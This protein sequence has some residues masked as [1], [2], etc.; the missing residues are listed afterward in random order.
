MCRKGLGLLG[1]LGLLVWL[2]LSSA[3][4][5]NNPNGWIQNTG[6]N[7]LFPIKTNVGCGGGGTGAMALNWTAPH[8]LRTEDPQ[9]GDSWNIGFQEGGGGASPA[10]RSEM[11]DF[12]GDGDDLTM[13]WTTV[14]TLDSLFASAT[15]A[16]DVVDFQVLAEKYNADICPLVANCPGGTADNDDVL[17]IATT[18]VE[19]VTGAALPVQICSASDDSI[20][21]YVNNCL[22]QNTSACRGT[23][24][25]CDAPTPFVV[26]LPPGVSKISVLVWEGGGG[27]GFRLALRNLGGA[28]YTDGNSAGVINFLGADPG[29][30]DGTQA[31]ECVGINR[32]YVAKQFNAPLSG[33]DS[34]TVTIRGNSSGDQGAAFT[35]SET[36]AVRSPTALVI[37]DVSNGGT[38][39]ENTV[40][41]SAE[42]RITDLPNAVH[43]GVDNGGLAT[44]SGSGLGPYSTT[45]SSATDIWEGGD[46]FEFQYNIVSGDFDIAVEILS[47]AHGSGTGRWGRYGLMARQ[48]DDESEIP[49]DR[50][51]RY[52]AATAK[53]PV[54]VDEITTQ[55]RTVHN[56][57]GGAGGHY[58][59]DF[60]PDYLSARPRFIRMTRRGNVVTAWASNCA[61]LAT[62]VADPYNDAN[63]TQGTNH[64]WGAGAPADLAVGFLNG[65]HNSSPGVPQTVEFRILPA[66]GGPATSRSS[67]T[68]TWNVTAADL[69]NGLS[70]KLQYSGKQVS[71]HT[72][73]LVGPNVLGIPTGISGVPFD[74]TQTGPIGVFDNSHD[75]GYPRSPG[76]TRVLGGGAYHIEGAGDDVWAGGDQFQYAYKAATGDFDLQMR[77]TARQHPQW[78]SRWGKHG[79][80]ARWTSDFNSRYTFN[81]MNLA[82][83]RPVDID[84]PRVARRAEHFNTGFTQELY[85]MDDGISGFPDRL[86]SYAWSRMIRRDN[87][88]Y[89]YFAQDDGGAPGTWVFSGSDNDPNMP[90]TIM[91][92]VACNAHAGREIGGFDFDNVSFTSLP[93]CPAGAGSA[94]APLTGTDFDD[95]DLSSFVVVQG[96]GFAPVGAGGRLQL[97]NVSTGGSAN[98]VWFPTDG[99]NIAAAGFTVDFDAYM[100]GGAP[101]ADG[102]T[103]AA[104]QGNAAFAANLRGDGGGALG[105]EGNKMLGES[106]GHPSFA[107]EMDNWEGGGFPNTEP[108]GNASP[109]NP[110]T[111]HMGID[112][113]GIV[114]SIQTTG[115]SS[116]S[117]PN[118]FDP[119]GVH[120]TVAYAPTGQIDVYVAANS[121]PSERRRVLSACI[122]PFTGP[123]LLIG[124]TAGTGGA[125]CTQEVDNAVVSALCSEANADT[126]SIS[127]AASSPAGTDVVLTGTIGGVDAGGTATYSW[128]IVSGSG[129]IVGAANGASVTISSADCG[130]TVV[131]LTGSDG[132]CSDSASARHTVTFLQ[133]HTVEVTGATSANA[134]DTVTLGSTTNALA[135]ATYAWAITGG[136]GE[137]VGAADGASVDVRGTAAGTLTVQLTV[138]NGCGEA[139]VDAHDITITAG[140]R[141]K[142]GDENQ[143][144]KFDLSDPV[145]VLNHLFLGTNPTLPCG[146]GTVTDAA[147]V[148]LL[149]SNGDGKID[150]SD[151]VHMLAFLFLGGPPPAPCAGNADC[152]CI[153]IV[154]CSNA[155]TE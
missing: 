86:D 91:V 130:T 74:N 136:S 109:G 17:G 148:A 143:D 67:V 147:N 9:D 73:A 70:Y 151:A 106:E 38:I 144:G 92:G 85:V 152:P 21:V 11:G 39:T 72:L 88:L 146:D 81:H 6:W 96:G 34:T 44:A 19:N 120:V 98:A 69:A 149:D 90:A 26:G 52:T 153:L 37:S 133:G 76:S 18:Y 139:V 75:V 59:N 108:P 4:A 128:S 65:S 114:S 135:P 27:W 142:P 12:D 54:W 20:A 145:S 68:I 25:D 58:N 154:N 118:M 155:C 116:N 97:T 87:A 110:G 49:G 22:V 14:A 137:I 103:F 46:D 31:N 35:V 13:P 125:V 7:L 40:A 95:G 41:D 63:W 105:F 36:I 115:A 1:A 23:A 122:A 131:A 127:G 77:I 83:N 45:D 84:Q 104:V 99:L 117:L 3:Q 82:T 43:V 100:T 134:G 42:P 2:G 32:S 16:N 60:Q 28:R 129:T 121:G 48:F 113:N 15:G 30:A 94:G 61:D 10:I 93:A 53:L 123:D 132:V 50:F 101:P 57:E 55:G 29:V 62:G 124:W 111:Y 71:S 126:A 141:Q 66:V 24:G 140:G 112:V 119:A 150:L 78:D 107:V 80:M 102:F 8:D 56:A 64:D 138:T 5:A 89:C 51:S 33:S 79:L 47:T